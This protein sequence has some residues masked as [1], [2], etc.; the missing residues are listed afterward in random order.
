MGSNFFGDGSKPDAGWFWRYWCETT[1]ALGELLRWL[2]KKEEERWA[3]D[4]LQLLD[5][6]ILRKISYDYHVLEKCGF[7][8]SMMEDLE[9]QRMVACAYLMCLLRDEDMMKSVDVPD[10]NTLEDLDLKWRDELEK[11]VREITHLF[12]RG[13]DR[14]PLL[15]IM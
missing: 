12:I 15:Q 10:G 3:E 2:R 6:A 9:Q 8:I 1:G 5:K 13:S 4:T 14:L 7:T 11:A